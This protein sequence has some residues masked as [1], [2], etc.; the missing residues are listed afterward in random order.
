[1]TGWNASQ[2][3]SAGFVEVLT[4]RATGV[5]IGYRLIGAKAGPQLVAAGTCDIAESVFHRVLSIPSL[6]WMRGNLVL[7]R[8]DVLH[9][10]IDDL[11]QLQQMGRIDRTLLLAWGGDTT[12][13]DQIVR[14][15]YHML[16]RACTEL[17]MISGRGVATG[18]QYVG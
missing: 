2:K 14:R 3:V 15:N 12:L 4:S 16:L 9:D 6:P 11:A 10:I 8:L 7:L 17:G 5:Q 18:F 1:M 13:V